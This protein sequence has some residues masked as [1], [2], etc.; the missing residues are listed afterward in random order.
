M[1]GFFGFCQLTAPGEIGGAGCALV[2][3]ELLGILQHLEAA[4]G[5]VA[6]GLREPGLAVPVKLVLADLVSLG[7]QPIERLF[8][9]GEALA[10]GR[11]GLV[12]KIL[13]LQAVDG[14]LVKVAG[15]FVI[16]LGGFAGTVV[17]GAH[18][19]DPA[20][21]GNAKFGGIVLVG[22][23]GSLQS[24]NIH[25]ATISMGDLTPPAEPT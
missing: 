12:G 23:A 17:V 13:C 22:R 21:I 9:V 5:F 24:G 6:V 16:F 25:Y 18:G 20:V 7:V 15:A 10:L 2:N 11:R 1:L 4:D 19:G 3:V 8:S 14:G